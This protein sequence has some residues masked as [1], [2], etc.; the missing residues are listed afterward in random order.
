MKGQNIICFAKDWSEDPTSNNQVMLV[1]AQENKVLWLN[2]IAMR[3]PTFTSGRDLGKVWHKLKSFF[4]GAE[5]PAPNLWVVTPIVL[6]FPHN[7]LAIAINRYILRATISYYRRKL[8][9]GGFQLWTFLPNAVEYVGNLGES[10]S[11]ITVLMSGP[12]SLI[13][14]ARRWQPWSAN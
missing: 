8:G 9:L 4:R 1:L 7:K 5:Q 12:A 13:S 6:P 10:L 2:S 11:C 3:R 14:M